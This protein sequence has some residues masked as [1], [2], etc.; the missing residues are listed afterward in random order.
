MRL[1]AGEEWGGQRTVREGLGV[2]SGTHQA[3]REVGRVSPPLSGLDAWVGD[4]AADRA[5]ARGGLEEGAESWVCCPHTL[6]AQN[7]SPT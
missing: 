1:G 4:V 5:G 3:L 7:P 6:V 2:R